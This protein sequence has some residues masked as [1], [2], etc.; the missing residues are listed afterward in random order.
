M[1]DKTLQRH[2]SD[3][4]FCVFVIAMGLGLHLPLYSTYPSWDGLQFSAP[5]LAF[6]SCILGLLLGFLVFGGLSDRMGRRP[7]MRMAMV[8]S[9]SSSAL[10]LMFPDGRTLAIT[11]FMQ[12]LGTALMLPTAVAY[13]QALMIDP[14]NK[15]SNPTLAIYWVTIS[16]M[17]GMCLGPALTSVC[18][19]LLPDR[20]GLSFYAQAL[21]L[22]WA[23]VRLH[24]LPEPVA[25]IP[26]R[27]RPP[28][29][30]LPH[31]TAQGV[32][33]GAS[34]LWIG[35]FAVCSLWGALN[36]QTKESFLLPSLGL[37]VSLMA[38][39][40]VCAHWWIR[41]LTPKQSARIGFVVFM[42]AHVLL[43]SASSGP[44]LFLSLFGFFFL[45]CAC[46]GFVFWGGLA[47]ACKAAGSEHARGG[48]GYLFFV[49]LGLSTGL[50]FFEDFWG[51]LRPQAFQMNLLV[52][53][54][55]LGGVLFGAALLLK[56]QEP[57]PAK[58]CRPP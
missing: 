27:L 58:A 28:S 38:G 10:L 22:M 46:F 5:T 34:S 50:V 54:F 3:L 7:V 42:F 23:F 4:A 12:G 18:V 37:I 26:F 8:L 21:G 52:F 2:A 48:A 41:Y 29:L 20:Q 16:T 56:E 32:W 47:S 57:A 49:S 30:Q 53:W 6:V 14:T 19:T 55:I 1:F 31:F 36:S 35:S 9:I 33:Y 39:G 24:N 15:T 44:V 13:M 43:L 25:R 45:G 17:S 51:P 40:G 11:R